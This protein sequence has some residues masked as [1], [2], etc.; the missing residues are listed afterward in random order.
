MSKKDKVLELFAG[1]GNLTRTLVE[2]GFEQIIAAEVVPLAIDHLN[3]LELPG[4]KAQVTDLFNEAGLSDFCHKH[5][6]AKILVLDPPRDGLVC[7]EP[8]LKHK[9]LEVIA[10]ISCDLATC[11]RDVQAFMTEGFTLTC[12]MPVDLFPHT[13]HVELCV[14]LIR[15]H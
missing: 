10:Y 6:D 5:R 12:V 3:N 2:L 4:V 7:I 14:L 13:P 1:S 9:G 11:M 8:L 15:N